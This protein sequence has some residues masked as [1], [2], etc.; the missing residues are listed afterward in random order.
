MVSKMLAVAAL[1]AGLSSPA[2][3]QG[4]PT[5]RGVDHVGVTVYDSKAAISFFEEVLGCR[6]H[7]KFGPFRDDKGDFMKN[8]LSVHPRAVINQITL[9]RCGNGSSIELLEYRA[10][11]QK[12]E[13][14]RNS[15]L[16]GHHVAFYV[17]D[18]NKALAYLKKNGIKT[19]F[20]PLTVKQGPAAGQTIIYF[21]APW[22]LQME[23]ISYPKGMAYEKTSQGKLWSPKDQ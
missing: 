7:V 21:L 20:G 1:A 9:V 15:D 12:T 17:D 10:P 8:L 3:G 5:M 13:R 19:F 4:M 18:I 14:P 23:L 2:Y 16:A 22:G 6:A 11:D